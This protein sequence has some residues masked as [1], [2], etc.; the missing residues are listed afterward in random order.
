MSRGSMAAVPIKPEYQ[1][2]LGRLLAPRWHSASPVARAAVIVSL[3]A[4]L[5]LIVATVLTLENASY[6][7]GGR[8]PFSFSYRNLYRVRPDPGGWVKVQR[9]GPGGRLEDSFAVE[10]LTLPVYGG[11]QSGELPLYAQG[12]IVGLRRRYRNFVLRGEGKTRVN[13]VP[14]Y[15]VVYTANI[16]GRRMFGRD[17]L[18]LPQRPGAREGVEIVMLTAPH[19]NPQVTSP[20]EVAGAGVLLRPLKTFTLG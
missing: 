15:D 2:T 16:E 14:A 20:L 17:V 19:A 13:S 8:V 4:L 11:A 3:G 10:P 6:T 9:R 7:H 1:P 5:A 12:Y 18:L